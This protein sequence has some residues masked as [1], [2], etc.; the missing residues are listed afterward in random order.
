[1][2][3]VVIV[4]A[5][6]NALRI[7]GDFVLRDGDGDD[8]DLAGRD[9]ISLCRCGASIN[10]PFCDG[11]HNRIFFKS[12]VKAKKLAPKPHPGHA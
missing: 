2:S 7:S 12:E 10:K 11:S 4:C 8:F 5:K 6:D 1:M 3:K 9:S